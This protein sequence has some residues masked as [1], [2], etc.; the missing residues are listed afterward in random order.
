MTEMLMRSDDRCFEGLKSPAWVPGWDLP[1]RKA[2]VREIT[3][4]KPST[5]DMTTLIDNFSGRSRETSRR[6]P[7]VWRPF[8]SRCV[9]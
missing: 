4:D 9:A 7:L 5:A 1:L 6:E 3:P 2:F 8:L